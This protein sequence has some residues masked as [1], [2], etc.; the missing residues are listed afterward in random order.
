MFFYT[1]KKSLQFFIVICFEGR[2]GIIILNFLLLW[3]TSGM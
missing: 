1:N 2:A 3:A